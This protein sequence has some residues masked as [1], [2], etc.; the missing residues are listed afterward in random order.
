ML[1]LKDVFYLVHAMFF[2]GG[3]E[4]QPNKYLTD[5]NQCYPSHEYHE[6]ILLSFSWYSILLFYL[7]RRYGKHLNFMILSEIGC[8]SI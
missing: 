6:L 1:V 8:T 2:R 7:V 5:T 4:F 3:E